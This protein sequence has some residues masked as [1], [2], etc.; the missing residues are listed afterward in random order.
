M[1][2]VVKIECF[3]SLNKCHR[4][5]LYLS[6][7]KKSFEKKKKITKHV[8]ILTGQYVKSVFR[9]FRCVVGS[10]RCIS[11]KL[12]IA[13]ERENEIALI[14]QMYVLSGN[15]LIQVHCKYLYIRQHLSPQ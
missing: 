2:L 3:L 11:I 4:K 8:S 10:E 5:I 7:T 9:F 12:K 14:K 1:L 6:I 13:Y 15:V